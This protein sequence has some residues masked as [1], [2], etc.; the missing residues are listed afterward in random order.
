[1]TTPRRKP[2]APL[3][4]LCLLP[5]LL[6][7]AGS[8]ARAAPPSGQTPAYALL[9]TRPS[10]VHDKQLVVGSID[11]DDHSSGGATGSEPTQ[12]HD[13]ASIRFVVTTEILEVSPKGSARRASIVV[14][15]LDKESGGVSVELA[16]PGEA[17]VARMVGHDR[18]V[19]QGGTPVAADLQQALAIAVPLRT[20]DE[21]TDDDLY[22]SAEPR[23][24]GEKWDVPAALFG[25]SGAQRVTFEPKTVAG[26][27][28]LAGQKAV[29]GVPCLELKWNVTAHNGSFK[30]GGLPGG[31]LGT[32]GSMTVSG[33]VV[34]PVDPRLP[35]VSRHLEIAAVGDLTG[36]T[37]EGTPLTVHR[38]LRQVFH[39]E[40]SKIP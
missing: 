16:K 35:P 3:F 7:G 15:R 33:T 21:P 38:D 9:L 37:D 34:V 31:L 5:L 39:V 40:F 24:V 27:V 32:L 6:G 22:G 28:T 13:K 4:S 8:A 2:A 30:A 10:A 29:H 11:T 18:V 20:D 1:M 23:R 14:R 25:A 12:R 36:T 17:F 19:E 26:S